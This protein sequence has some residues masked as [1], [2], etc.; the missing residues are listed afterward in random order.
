[1]VSNMDPLGA[2]SSFSARRSATSN[3]PNFELPPPQ[4][5]QKYPPYS[6]MN[7]TQP[8]PA[9]VSVGNLLTPPSNMSGESLSPISSGMNAPGSGVNN[10]MSAYTPNGFWPHP[11]ASTNPYG[12]SSGNTPQA[13]GQGPLN[14]LFPAPRGMFS[15]SLGSLMR[16]NSNSPTTTEGLP[17]PPYDFNQLPPFSTSMSMSAPPALGAQQQA[18]ANVMMSTQT[19]VSSSATQASPIHASESYMQRPSLTPSYYSGSQPSSTPQQ[20]QFPSYTAASPV[21][22]SPMTSNGASRISPTSGQPPHLHSTAPQQPPHFSRP[23][24]SYPLP[25]MTGPVMTNVH[26]PG[27]QMAMVGGMPGGMMPAFNSGHAAM[28]MY[29]NPHAAQQPPLNDRPFKCDQCPQSFNRNH[30]LKRHKRIHLAVK[31]FPCGHCDKSFSRK[32]ALKVS[33]YPIISRQVHPLIIS[34][35]AH[36]RQRLRQI[37]WIRL[38]NQGKRLALSH[39]E[40]RSYR[41]RYRRQFNP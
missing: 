1:M 7:V 16:N 31:P 19:P 9:N 27:S 11:T 3:L 26:S 17:P 39:W 35:E 10:G 20:G 23:F 21:Q 5:S 28:Q 12:F 4:L 34:A 14:P 18:M 32:D 40:I 41:H 38:G 36:P 29:G 30:D 24:N 15:P 13:W 8:S 2:P 33:Q 37:S 22:Q 6:T 25:A